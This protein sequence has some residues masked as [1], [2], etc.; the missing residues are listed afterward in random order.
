MTPLRRRCH[1]PPR[2]LMPRAEYSVPSP[3]TCT[4]VVARRN[5]LLASKTTDI[6]SAEAREPPR[7]VEMAP[8]ASL[9]TACEAAILEAWVAA[10]EAASRADAAFV[11]AFAAA[12][13]AWDAAWESGRAAAEEVE[14]AGVGV[15]GMEEDGEDR[16]AALRD[17]ASSSRCSG[18]EEAEESQ[19]D[20]KTSL[21]PRRTDG[22]T[23]KELHVCPKLLGAHPSVPA[24]TSTTAEVEAVHHDRP[25]QRHLAPFHK[26]PTCCQLASLYAQRFLCLH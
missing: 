4:A 25:S 1:S 2:P 20:K 13:E 26:H 7:G 15:G 11:M 8:V 16:P 6:V 10:L 12:W 21:G 19:E 22:A 18:Q 14:R 9:E 23:R 17:D 3:V 24:R 5:A